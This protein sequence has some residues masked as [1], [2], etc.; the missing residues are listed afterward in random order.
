MPTNTYV[1]LDKITVGTAT[2]SIT[3]TGISQAYTDLI[4]VINGQCSSG[5]SQNTWL[6]FN[7]DT[8]TN[9]SS[10]TLYGD[11]TSAVSTRNSNQTKGGFCALASGVNST[12]IYQIQNYSN[13]TTYKTVLGRGN[14]SNDIVDTRVSLWRKTPEAITSIVVG[15]SGGVNY[16]VGSTFSLYGIKAE[17]FAAKATGGTIAYANGYWTHTFT[18]SGTFTPNQALTCDYLVVAGGGAGGG[19]PQFFNGGAGGGAGGYRTSIGGSSLSLLSSTNYTV[20]VGAGG[21]GASGARGSNGADSVFSTITSTGGGRG[22]IEGSAGST[23]GSGGAASGVGASTVVTG[24]AGNTPST[25]PS[26]GNNGGNGFGEWAGGGGGAN[27]NGANGSS[28][29]AG[30]G[31]NGVANS[32]SGSSVTYAGGGGGGR[33]NTGTFG[34]GGSGGGGTAVSGNG[35]NGTANTGGGGAGSSDSTTT[36]RTGGNGG[37]GIVIIR[38]A[39]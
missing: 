38:Y 25:S 37:S 33:Y 23:G 2:P 18:S 24:Y 14:V 11:G 35:G 36:A 28:G 17:P 12:V 31:G 20:T 21:A 1:A 32:I 8:A 6:N 10:T 22:G 3:F 27:A 34:T 13:A 39:N 5:G 16:N 4:L 30:N 15:I 7:S 19:Q 9:Y 26:Q 29:V